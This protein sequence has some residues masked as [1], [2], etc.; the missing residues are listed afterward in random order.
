VIALLATLYALGFLVTLALVTADS[1]PTWR[2]I[3][4][5]FLTW[6]V[7]ALLFTLICALVGWDEVL[8]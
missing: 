7:L 6:W 3:G 1:T 2:E 4:W 5:V 8:P